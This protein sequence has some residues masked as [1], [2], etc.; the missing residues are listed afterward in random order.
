MTQENDQAIYINDV[1]VELAEMARAEGFGVLA[2][3]LDMALLE[4]ESVKR[5]CHDLQRR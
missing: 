4:A 2:Y 1:L 5:Q 3:L